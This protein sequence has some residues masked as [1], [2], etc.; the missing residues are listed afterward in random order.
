MY[1]LQIKMPVFKK[2]YKAGLLALCL[3]AIG[4]SG[5]VFSGVD[6]LFYPMRS[7]WSQSTGKTNLSIYVFNDLNGNG[8]YDLGDRALSNIATGLSQNQTP[9]SVARTNIN[10][11][12]N[13]AA[14]TSHSS[15]PIALPGLYSF[16]VFVPPGWRVS[17]QNRVQLRE[18]TLVTG[19]GAGLGMAE[20]L[21]PVGLERYKFIRG[22]YNMPA[23][24]PLALLQNGTIIAETTLAPDEEFLWP[25][26]PGTYT[27]AS[28][29]TQRSVQ[30]GAYPVDIGTFSPLPTA[31]GP[32]R[33]I[34][35]ENM[36]PS[37]LQ[38]APNGYGGLNWFNLNIISSTNLDS[39]IGYVNGATSGHNIL[40]NSSGHAGTI[41]ADTPFTFA[42]VN[43]SVAWPSAE[44]E[45]AIF[46]FY[47]GDTLVLQDRIGLSA[48]GPITYQPKVA[49]I[50]RIELST[51]HNWQLVIDDIAVNT[52]P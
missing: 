13:Y 2:T 21:H 38:K 48:Y 25:V 24:G 17:T 31:N 52:Q 37:G 42:A 45:T 4:G 6:D 19:S 51:A 26:A 30:V 14:S 39:N 43:L 22:T 10:G 32:S 9:A 36:A 28:G 49:G 47:R 23:A 3:L 20:M 18:L 7:D 27:L 12:A 5:P 29:S 33:S 44:G 15:A 40:Y 16:E 34:G 11:F 35:F 8:I 46:S 50:T 41:Y 1:E